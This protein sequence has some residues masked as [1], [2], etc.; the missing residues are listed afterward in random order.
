MP[1]YGNLNMQKYAR[2]MSK[3]CSAP[4]GMFPLHYMHYMHKK[5]AKICQTSRHI[6]HMQKYAKICNPHFADG[7]ISIS[8]KACESTCITHS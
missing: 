3:I 5:Y 2:N 4:R 7:N 8:A 1:L 6:M